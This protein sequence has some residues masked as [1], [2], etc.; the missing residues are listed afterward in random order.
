MICR[1]GADRAL[2]QRK[3]FNIGLSSISHNATRVVFQSYDRG[4]D[5]EESARPALC[6]VSTS[7]KDVQTPKLVFESEDV[8]EVAPMAW[9]PDDRFIAVTL[10]RAD[11]TAQIGL[12]SLADGSLR[13]LQS[14]EW[15][16]PTRVVF[17]PDGKDLAFDLPVSESSDN[18]HI[19]IRAV[20]G[21]A[22]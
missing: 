5:G 17:S 9:S 1:T 6:I 16:G 14:V 10:R 7:E 19:A 3:D 12:V 15:R 4:C 22:G 18:R 13:V 21:A 8:I 20:D 2:T 11:R